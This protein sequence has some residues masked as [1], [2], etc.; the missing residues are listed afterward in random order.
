MALT[1][2][3]INEQVRYLEEIACY[4][5]ILN[6]W[7]LL[8]IVR[9]IMMCGMQD[10][11]REELIYL[12]GLFDGEGTI[13]INS[14]Y[15]KKWIKGQTDMGFAPYIRIGMNDEKSIRGVADFFKVGHY[16]PEKSY[17]GYRAMH[18]WACRK[19]ADLKT[20]LL[21][22]EPFLRL[23][24]PQCNLALRFLDECCRPKGIRIGIPFSKEI[25]DKRWDFYLRIKVLNGIDISDYSPATTKRM[26]HPKSIRD[27]SYS[28]N[29]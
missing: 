9:Y 23:K 1:G 14:G 26:G 7:D 4:K 12:A 15:S 11:Q 28:L 19:Q 3:V 6:N 22:L 20:V 24:K 18:R 25:C 29:S 17:K 10:N 27:A 8:Y 21:M 16:Y 2:C 13:G 5:P